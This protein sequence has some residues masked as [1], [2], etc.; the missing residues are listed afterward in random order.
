MNKT[1]EVIPSHYYVEESDSHRMV[2]NMGPQHPSTHGV[3]RL[4]LELDGEVCTRII[5][6]LGYLHT[7]IEKLSEAHN[8]TKNITHY[9]RMDYLAPMNNEL[10]YCLAVEKLIGLEIPARASYIRVIMSEIS[11][12]MS[13]LLWLGT[14]ALDI[15]ASSVFMYATTEREKLLELYELTGGQR[16]MTSYIR[17]GGV[18]E[19]TP[20]GFDRAVRAWAEGFGPLC[21]MLAGLLSGNPIWKQRTQNIGYL[22]PQSVISYG[23]MGP[24]MRAVG[25]K[26]D[27]RKDEPYCRYDEFEFDVPVFTEG[28]VYARYQVRLA[29]MYESR[30]IILQGLEKLHHTE[31]G[32]HMWISDHF[33]PPPR[34]DIN[35]DI[36]GLIHHFKYWTEGFKPPAGEAYA[37]IESGK[38]ELGF[39]VVSDG[40]A[41]PIRVKV[42]GASFCNL[43]ALAAMCEG[44]M[45]ADVA[46]IIGSIDIVLGEVDR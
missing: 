21:D 15:G 10:A 35:A 14:H 13:H 1:A 44:A 33:A 40:S 28:D 7:G 25:I 6:H 38:G 37:C 16:M 39:Y 8:Y 23:L 18:K 24:I 11:R 3:L 46:A 29:E 9:P 22:D 20:P 43:A 45:I 2:L 27:I 26:Q 17:V 32:T 34:R 31:P 41:K 36:E 5:P 42:R 19:D 30:K 12:C 4:V